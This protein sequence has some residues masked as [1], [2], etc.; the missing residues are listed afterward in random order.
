METMKLIAQT[1][2]GFEYLHS[3]ELAFFAPNA[4]ADKICKVMNDV[5]FRLKNENEIYHVYEYDI[6]QDDYVMHRL[7]IYKG[8]VKLRTL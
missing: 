4:S 5:R 1:V 8:I 7:S 3:K 6:M 2:K